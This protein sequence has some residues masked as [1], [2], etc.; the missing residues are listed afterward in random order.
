MEF[1]RQSY[2]Y[3]LQLHLVLDQLADYHI[4]LWNGRH[5]KILAHTPLL[6]SLNVVVTISEAF[7][8]CRRPAFF[9]VCARVRPCSFFLGVHT[10]GHTAFSNEL[11]MPRKKSHMH[12]PRRKSAGQLFSRCTVQPASFT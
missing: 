7:P 1:S 11:Y 5:R 12:V 4:S 9:L 8:Q 3:L 10:R 2:S 6:P